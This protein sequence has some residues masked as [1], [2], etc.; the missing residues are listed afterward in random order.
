MNLS[1]TALWRAVRALLDLAVPSVILGGG[2]Y[3]PWTLTRYWAGLWAVIADIP[4]PTDLP[5]AATNLL[6][7]MECDLVDEEDREPG[8]LTSMADSPYSGPVRDTIESI[9]ASVVM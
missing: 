8:W 9:A 7:A 3:N 2:G 5:E 1:N 4:V 6:A